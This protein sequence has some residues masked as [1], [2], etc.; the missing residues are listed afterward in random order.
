MKLGRIFLE[1]LLE[2]GG[3][4]EITE[5]FF[6]NFNES[7]QKDPDAKKI[8]EAMKKS[9]SLKDIDEYTEELKKL[10]SEKLI[11]AV[12]L[13]LFGE[14][15][16]GEMT[17]RTK[18]TLDTIRVTSSDG[19]LDAIV[20][21]RFSDSG[22]EPRPF[23]VL[24]DYT[25]IE[26]QLDENKDEK[27][28]LWVPKGSQSKINQYY[29]TTKRVVDRD[30]P[31]YS[32]TDDGKAKRKYSKTGETEIQ[33]RSTTKAPSRSNKNLIRTA[34]AG[35]VE[36]IQGFINAYNKEE[37]DD[38][39]WGRLLNPYIKPVA[40]V[41]P[42]DEDSHKERVGLLLQAL[43]QWALDKEFLLYSEADPNKETIEI[44]G[45]PQG[46]KVNIIATQGPVKLDTMLDI[47]NHKVDLGRTKIW[48]QGIQL[49][50][51]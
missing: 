9:F 36:K 5:D 28:P 42:D 3:R 25:T 15:F 37:V 13:K 50:G 41:D 8:R 43:V 24:S 30:S 4:I 27:T 1:A 16:K 44:K 49:L 29:S 35:T 40:G 47:K 17:F 39:I 34:A 26:Y 38:P 20:S 11:N 12:F 21:A 2:A 10:I 22:R 51:N 48:V 14:S 45:E 6:V 33:T 32:Y 46:D 19:R 23:K 18:P 31:I 7:F